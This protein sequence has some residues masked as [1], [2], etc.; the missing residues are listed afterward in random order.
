MRQL[1]IG[2]HARRRGLGRGR[3]P[4][5]RVDAGIDG[6]GFRIVRAGGVAV[7]GA[8]SEETAGVEADGIDAGRDSGDQF[9]VVLQGVWLFALELRRGI[10][11]GGER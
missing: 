6:V 5:P 11:D 10:L 9:G 8:G 4:H 2:P 1:R 7:R 3:L